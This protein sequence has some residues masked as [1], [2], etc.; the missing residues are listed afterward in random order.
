VDTLLI[1][2]LS[3]GLA[4]SIGLLFLILYLNARKDSKSLQAELS[5]AKESIAVSQN[6]ENNLREQLAEKDRLLA[7]NETDID[8]LRQRN[9]KAVAEYAKLQS[10]MES[11]RENF[12]QQKQQ[13]EA[14]KG[15]MKTEF[16]NLANK[17]FEDKGKSFTSS[18]EQSINSM[19]RPFREQIDG[20]QKRIN[21]LHDS[22]L[23]ESGNLN[24]EI[25]KVLDIGLK[26]SEEATN[27]SKALKGDSQQRGAW[28]EAQLERTLEMSGLILDEHFEKQS[29]FKDPEG[30][31]KQ[32]DYLIKLPDNKHIIIDSKV[33]MVAYDRAVNAET[34]ELVNLAMA[35]HVKSVRKHIDDLASK[36]YTNLIG[37][38]SPSFVLMFMPIEPAYID[39]LKS[40]KDLFEYGYNKGI[41]LVSH[42]TL[43]PIL[44]T[45]ANL[46]M[47]DRS[48][49]EARAI[50]ES[51][52]D[53][54]N[55][56]CTV[57]ERV[58]KLGNTLAAA[59][60]HYNSAVTSLTGAQGLY[61]KVDRFKTLSAKVSKTLPEL[62]DK[63]HDFESERL[64][65]AVEAIK[66]EP[67]L[68]VPSHNELD[69]LDS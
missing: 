40:N 36:D 6:I 1:F 50:S 15:V 57:S 19:L 16:E 9:E 14:T 13:F 4:S 56:V 51:A 41:I 10:R 26:M 65:I 62:D 23:K 18:S 11:D 45:V 12:E 64:N 43:I 5:I 17:I 33:T 66:T 22:S 38:Q 29:S 35:E 44:K 48:N 21:D 28:G 53:I 7:K 8:N 27:L 39:A 20:F 46:W 69:T 32:T 2:Q 59:S 61:G 55:S 68:P 60:N 24:A 34:P 54:F 3:T 52:A 49:K 42:T 63:H 67:L 37:M 25:K 30:R 31:N 47:I 58:Q